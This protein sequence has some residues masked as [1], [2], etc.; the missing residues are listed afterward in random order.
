[1]ET[2][3]GQAAQHQHYV[4]KFLLRNFLSDEA[5]EQVQVFDKSRSSSFTTNIRGIMAERRFNEF[6][7]DDE[8]LA[9]FEPA[10]CRIEEQVLPVYREVVG[11]RALSHTEEE[12]AYLAYFMAFQ[13]VRTRSQRDRFTEM[14]TLIRDKFEK[15]GADAEQLAEFDF[16]QNHLKMRHADFMENALKEFTE[17]IARK[18]YILIE[19]A[20]GRTFYI[21]DT[22]VVMHNSGPRDP[23]WGN[24]GLS[25]LGIEIYLPLTSNLLLAAWCP[26]IIGKHRNEVAEQRRL[27]RATLLGG[28]IRRTITP[29]HMKAELARVDALAKPMDDLIGHADGGTPYVATDGMMDLFNSLQVSYATRHVISP[30]GN[31]GIAKRFM[32]E[33][34]NNTGRKMRAD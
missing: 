26:S 13:M 28:V 33:N 29:A 17:T 6:V 32:R 16:D 22:P 14:D 15:M 24:I 9:T 21:G 10:I 5:K 1:M 25:V 27:L 12:R 23:F 3:P 30:D 19:A 7:V 2:K 20:P 11:N 18:D 34:P 8:W 4:P 31:W